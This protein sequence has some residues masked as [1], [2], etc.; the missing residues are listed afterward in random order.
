MVSEQQK[1]VSVIIPAYNAEKFI[2][3]TVGNVLNQSWKNLELIIINDGSTDNTSNIL[4]SFS[5]DSR[6]RVVEQI[7]QGCSAA[8]NTGLNYARGDFIQY[9]DADD[10][11]SEDKITQQIEALEDEPF[12]IAVCK[13]VVFQDINFKETGFE[14]DT[15]YLYST[16][17]RFEFLM[18][19]YGK[20][21]KI[22]MIQPNAFL[23]PKGLV[24]K[25]GEW[26]TSLS[27]SP[28]EDGE[29]FCRA[30]LGASK[31]I[32]TNGTNYYRKITNAASLSKGKSFLFAKGALK[33]V[34]LKAQHVLEINDSETVKHILSRH[35]ASVAYLYGPNFYEIVFMVKAELEKMGINKIPSVGGFNFKIVSSIIGFEKAIRLKRFLNN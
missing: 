29:Y 23:L 17:N 14:I 20:N 19:L 28:D 15:D 25:I 1:L 8:K 27:P 9:L 2:S 16:E 4:S 33:S 7:N 12:G 34:Q 35:F 10:I 24:E 26:N 3:E 32:Y 18:N 31:I 11:L 6:I 5:H 13:T 22:G 30:V 21:G